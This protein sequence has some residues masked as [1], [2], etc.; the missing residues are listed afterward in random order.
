M[1]AD[2]AAQLFDSGAEQLG[3]SDSANVVLA[4]DCGFQHLIRVYA[5]RMRF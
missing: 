3:I 2:G 5:A 1:R 4:E